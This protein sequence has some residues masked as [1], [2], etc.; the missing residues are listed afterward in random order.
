MRGVVGVAVTARGE[1]GDE[2]L[3]LGGVDA[4]GQRVERVVG[5]DRH[6]GGG[7]HRAVVDALV[8]HE[9]HHHAGAR[10][11]R[12]RWNSAKARSMA[13]GAGQLAGQR[14]VEV[15]DHAGE[16][17]EEAHREDAHPAGSTTRSGSKPLTTS[18]RRAS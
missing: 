10:C 12:P 18:A 11:A 14:R 15:D 17:A 4:F 7:E 13:C 6:D 5:V 1:G 2:Q 16:P 3:V 8:G 9:V